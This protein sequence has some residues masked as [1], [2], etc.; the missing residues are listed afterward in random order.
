M[1]FFPSTFLQSLLLMTSVS[2][3]LADTLSISSGEQSAPGILHWHELGQCGKPCCQVSRA[4][5][6]ELKSHDN[7][8][9][10][11]PR[12]KQKLNCSP[13]REEGRQYAMVAPPFFE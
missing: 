12:G 2:S 9:R 1:R 7:R 3:K 8:D 4:L 5:K 11:P 6:I 13:L 10:N